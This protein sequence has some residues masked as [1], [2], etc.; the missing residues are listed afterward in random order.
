M[1]IL[2]AEDH[3]LIAEGLRHFLAKENHD[4]VHAS[5]MEEVKALLV[6]MKPQILIQDIRIGQTDART[7]LPDI[8]KT[9]PD[10]QIFIL[11]SLDDVGTIQSSLALGVQGYVIKSENLQCVIHAINSLSKGKNYLSPLTRELLQGKEHAEPTIH[12]SVREKEVLKGIL[13]ERSTREIAEKIFVS[14]KTVEHYRSSLFVKFNVK[15]VSGLVKK[16]ILSGF[17]KSI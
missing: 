2:I 17:Y 14:E 6:E 5:H 8:I 3:S 12:L 11:T 13:E 16:A 4:I 9:Y 10:L 7:Y 1:T 15:N